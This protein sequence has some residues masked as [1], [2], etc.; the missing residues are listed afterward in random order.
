MRATQVGSKEPAARK[1]LPHAR[2]RLQPAPFL[3]ADAGAFRQGNRSR[4]TERTQHPHDIPQ[5]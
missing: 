2:P 1:V 5:W 3:A 4:V